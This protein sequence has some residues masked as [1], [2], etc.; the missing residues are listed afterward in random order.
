MVATPSMADDRC[1]PPGGR[2]L[3]R[4]HKQLLAVVLGVSRRQGGWLAGD[5]CCQPGGRRLWPGQ[6]HLLGAEAD[7]PGGRPM[8]SQ[9]RGSTH[10]WPPVGRPRRRSDE[11]LLESGRAL[12]TR[13]FLERNAQF[14]R[15]LD[16]PIV[17]GTVSCVKSFV[18][19]FGLSTCTRKAGSI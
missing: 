8:S 12:L 14:A 15:L 17:F 9:G 19:V 1:C 7:W 16:A 11:R 6:L 2:R 10:L 5:C 3:R 13:L 18:M 4:G